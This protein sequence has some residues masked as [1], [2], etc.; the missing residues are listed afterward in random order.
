M[1]PR[2]YLSPLASSVNPLHLWWTA[3]DLPS[4][5]L[6]FHW[7]FVQ[8]LRYCRRPARPFASLYLEHWRRYPREKASCRHKHGDRLHCVSS[9]SDRLRETLRHPESSCARLAPRR[10]RQ[11]TRT[12]GP[13]SQCFRCSKVFPYPAKQLGGGDRCACHDEGSDQ[14]MDHWLATASRTLAR[15]RYEGVR[16]GWLEA[17]SRSRIV[18]QTATKP[19]ACPRRPRSRMPADRAAHPINLRAHCRRMT[20]TSSASMPTDPPSRGTR[21]P[22]R[23]PTSHRSTPP[24][25]LHPVQEEAWPVTPRYCLL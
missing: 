4:C 8:Q 12:S 7:D 1:V 2:S 20:P 10:R 17:A 3:T 11:I 21:R 6:W 24:S 14:I 9:F 13:T 23:S 22:H 18:R 5:R 16:C 15:P 19:A 25:H